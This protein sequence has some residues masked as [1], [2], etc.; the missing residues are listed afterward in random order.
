MA[1]ELNVNEQLA[2]A[3]KVAAEVHLNQT[4]K[5]GKPYILHPLHLMNQ[6]L[7]DTELAIIA[8]LH[9]VI[10]DS[11]GQITIE[12]LK[13]MGFS[14][15]VLVALDLLTHKDGDTYLG[16]YIAGICTNIDA[17]T[18]KRKDL[19][20]NS[21]ITR[22]KGLREKDLQRISKYHSAFIMLGD[23]RKQFKPE[24]DDPLGR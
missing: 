16:V 12:L 15:R 5:S 20:H 10:E 24:K 18:V 7:Y 4:D 11:N 17:I 9:D 19:E 22:L 1:K 3:I 6:L 13:W 8:V 23:A 21:S 14:E 2:L